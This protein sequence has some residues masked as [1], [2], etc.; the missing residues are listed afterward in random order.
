MIMAETKRC[1]YCGEE[2]LAVAKKCKHCGEWLDKEEPKYEKKMVACPVC[3]E[4]I[5]EGTEICPYCHEHIGK[6]NNAQ[7]SHMQSQLTTQDNG[8]EDIN[9]DETDTCGED[10][11]KPGLLQYCYFD[12]FFKHY[13]DFEGKLG[14]ARFWGAYL[15]NTLFTF[16]LI[17]VD[18]ALF[19]FPGIL[20]SIY[21]LAVLVPSIAFMVRRLHD[22]G[23][24]GWF[25]L[26]G[27]IP[28]IGTIALIVLLCMRGEEDNYQKA[29]FKTFDYLA[30]GATL[31][32]I[33]IC[34]SVIDNKKAQERKDS[35]ELINEDMPSDTD[36]ELEEGIP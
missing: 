33:I 2:I 25:V 18:M 24:S 14:R 7:H 30:I 27:L 3:G 6:S 28:V 22:S 5:E 16:V 4:D 8:N 36:S 23:K 11:D 31:A 13:A 20:S 32:I 26:L 1:P 21:G 35:Q 34:G 19:G 29:K 17:A 10:E 12:V 15:F 9:N